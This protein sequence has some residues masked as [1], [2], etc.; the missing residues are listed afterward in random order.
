MCERRKM[1]R[2]EGVGGYPRYPQSIWRKDH[3]QIVS[4]GSGLE[5]NDHSPYLYRKSCVDKQ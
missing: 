4:W 1:R 3:Q 5:R 2:R